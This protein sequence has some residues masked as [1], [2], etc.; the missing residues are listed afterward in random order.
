MHYGQIRRYDIANGIGIR[1]TIF[2]TGCTR[3]CPECFNT[4]YQDFNAGKEWTN[5][6][7]ELIISYLKDPNVEGLTLLGGEPMQNTE[8]LVEIVKAIKKEVDKSVWV[9]S[10]YKWEEILQDPNK[11]ALLE[12]CDVLVDGP[13][14]IAL[15]DM[16][17]RFRGSSNQRIIDIQE[18]LKQDKIVL[19]EF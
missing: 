3:K 17:L 10:G 15:R 11:K 19:Y 2:V 9:Y 14:I 12:I 7:T 1:S 6:E 18:S 4:E 8:G 13:F 5:K 16:R